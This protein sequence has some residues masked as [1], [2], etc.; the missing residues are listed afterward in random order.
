MNFQ[1]ILYGKP[2]SEHLLSFI[3]LQAFNFEPCLAIVQVGN[4][5]ASDLYIKFK[6]KKATEVEISTKL[7]KFDENISYEDLKKHIENLNYD[8]SIHGI[9]IQMPLPFHLS[10][11]TQLID[12]RKD[13]DG[14]S[15]IQQGR[16]CLGYSGLFPCTALGVIELLKFYNIQL[17]SKKVAII[18]RSSLVGKPLSLMFLHEN[19]LVSILHSKINFDLMKKEL[20]NCD[21]ICSAVGK[22]HFIKSDCV[23]KGSVLIDIGVTKDQSETFGDIDPECYIDSLAYTPNIGGVGPMTIACLLSN[24]VKSYQKNNLPK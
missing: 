14:L 6:M 13:V 10:D 3:K 5:S 24:V 20:L 7:F 9:I 17:N 16:L 11:I 2:A 15:V 12:Y 4:N 8:Q 1:K 18:G 19:S 23:K 21:I 22:K